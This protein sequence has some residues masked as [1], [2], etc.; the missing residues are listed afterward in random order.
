ME[1]FIN[2]IRNTDKVVQSKASSSK[3]QNTCFTLRIVE[4]G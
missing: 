4:S 2:S 1:N 3:F